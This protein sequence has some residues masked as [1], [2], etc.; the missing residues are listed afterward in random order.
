MFHRN[1]LPFDCNY[2]N[3][4]DQD[5]KVIWFDTQNIPLSKNMWLK[6]TLN[7]NPIHILFLKFEIN[8]VT[9]QVVIKNSKYMPFWKEKSS[10]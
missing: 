3:R 10:I 6:K 4:A 7:S 2:Y 8:C 5:I 9:C 1:F